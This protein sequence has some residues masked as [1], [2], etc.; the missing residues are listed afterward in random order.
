MEIIFD[1]PPFSYRTNPQ[2]LHTKYL[3]ISHD[4]ISSMGWFSKSEME[5]LDIKVDFK[6]KP[7][8]SGFKDPHKKI[9]ETRKLEPI[10]EI[11]FCRTEK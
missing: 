9:R 4:T 6:E 8:L 3:K 10:Y 1:S 7:L 11:A 2:P 5:F